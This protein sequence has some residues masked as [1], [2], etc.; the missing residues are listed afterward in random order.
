MTTDVQLVLDALAN[1]TLVE[2]QVLCLLWFLLSILPFILGI[3]FM[4]S[5]FVYYQDDKIR[6]RFD[7]SKWTPFSGT[8]TVSP[9]SAIMDGSMGERNH[10][11]FSNKDAYSEDP[12]KHCDSQDVRSNK[13]AEEHLAQDVHRCSLNKDFSAITID[14]KPKTS[15]AFPTNLRRHESTFRS[16]EVK[17]QKVNSKRNVPGAQNERSFSSGLSRNFSS[18]SGDQSTFLL[19]EEL[20]LEHVDHSHHDHYLHKR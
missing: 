17:V 6:R 7:W 2:I 8:S 9:S 5:F 10:G 20:E 19:D 12:K 13:D 11:G 15:S 4:L 1:S 14:E 18:F 3:W 16:G